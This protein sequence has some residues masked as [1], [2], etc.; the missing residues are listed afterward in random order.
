VAAAPV[1]NNADMGVTA[2]LV[3]HVLAA[4]DDF[5]TASFGALVAHPFTVFRNKI[6]IV[7]HTPPCGSF[8]GLRPRTSSKDAPAELPTPLS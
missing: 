7:I 6:H 2:L 5:V 3:R 4:A 8:P 1:D